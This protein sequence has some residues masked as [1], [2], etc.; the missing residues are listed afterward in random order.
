MTLEV[1]A[2]RAEDWPA[3]FDLWVEAWAAFL[4]EIDFAARLPWFRGYVA[5]LQGRGAVVLAAVIE[6]VPLG[7]VT[8]DAARQDM[9]QLVTAPASQGRGIGRR[10]VQ[11]A[12]ENSPEGLSLKVVQVNGPAI[13][14]YRSEGF[15]ITGEGVSE[16][17]GLANF[18][19]RWPGAGSPQTEV[20]SRAR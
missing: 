9:D 3:L 13:A 12:K 6:G 10:L 11:T 14:L 19:M 5:D 2:A 16:R 7:F 17:S 18:S 8:V 20:R 15:V 4:P 1:R